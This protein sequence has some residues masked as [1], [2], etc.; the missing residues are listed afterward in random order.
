MT[1]GSLPDTQLPQHNECTTQRAD[2]RT[3]ASTRERTR[4]RRSEPRAESGPSRVKP[5]GANVGTP[6]ITG[7]AGLYTATENSKM[8]QNHMPGAP[9]SP[10]ARPSEG[11][12]NGTAM[13][14]SA[15]PDALAADAL[16]G[17]HASP[18]R[19]GN[20]QRASGDLSARFHSSLS[21]QLPPLALSFSDEPVTELA[22][23]QPPQ[24]KLAGAPVQTLP[25]LS[26]VTGSQAHATLSKPPEPSHPAPYAAPPTNHWPSLNPFTTYYTPS[27][28]DPVESSPSMG[29]DRS[30][31][32]RGA[33]VSLDDPD[34][35]IA[36]E[37]LGQMRTGEFATV[38]GCLFPAV[39]GY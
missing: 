10:Q 25:P 6:L 23:I 11:G 33:S 17:M 2:E 13:H 19:D 27:H 26:S 15:S 29:S 35:R 14:N 34:V 16:A 24:E 37:A 28:L 21:L 9:R 8:E 12:P 7:V 32:L 31:S 18:D 22:P 3:I 36:A 20:E 39:V 38:L 5:Y 30:G 4:E 1:G